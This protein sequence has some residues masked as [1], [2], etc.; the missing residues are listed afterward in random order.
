MLRTCLI[1]MLIVVGPLTAQEDASWSIERSMTQYIFRHKDQPVASYRWKDGDIRRPFFFHLHAPGGRQ[2]TRNHPPVAGKDATDHDTFHPGLWMSFGDVNGQDFWRNKARVWKEG[3]GLSR[4]DPLLFSEQLTFIGTDDAE[5]GKQENSVRFHHSD[6]GYLLIW[7]ARF[8][9]VS[10]DLVFGDQEEMGLGVRLHTD[11]T[12]KAGGTIRDSEG[13][14][15]EKGVWGK[16]ASWCAYFRTFATGDKAEHAGVAI[17]ADPGNFR[18]S[19]WHVR[20]YGL[21][22]ANPFGR[23]AFTRGEKSAVVVKKGESLTLRYG[24]LLFSQTGKEPRLEEGHKQF[25]K[26][27]GK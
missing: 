8:R 6:G 16:T 9:A 20:D 2:L 27:I 23:N 24:I 10:K 12:V 3:E 14:V 22:V 4:G 21:M 1:T 25:L 18:P 5:E 7:Q 13:R 19:W 15:N 17:F 26:L 11:L